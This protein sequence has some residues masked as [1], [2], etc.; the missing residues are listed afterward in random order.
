M[1]Y[2]PV[3]LQKMTFK[4]PQ[5]EAVFLSTIGTLVAYFARREKASRVGAALEGGHRRV[6]T[7]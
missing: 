5:N 6:K 1:A 3:A 2:G 4:P 7:I